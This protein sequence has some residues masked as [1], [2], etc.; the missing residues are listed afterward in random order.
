MV[1]IVRLVQ[2]MM[3]KLQVL[4]GESAIVGVDLWDMRVNCSG[5]ARYQDESRVT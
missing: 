3:S 2:V 1:A 5:W 4:S